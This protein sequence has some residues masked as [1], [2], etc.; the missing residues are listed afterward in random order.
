[1]QRFYK[2][3]LPVILTFIISG[4][5]MGQDF[6]PKLDP[7]KSIQKDTGNFYFKEIW[8]QSKD[9]NKNDAGGYL[10]RATDKMD[11]GFF[12]EALP[13][14]DKSIGIDSTIGYSYFLKGVINLKYDSS[15]LALAAFKKAIALKDDNP[16]CFLYS[17]QIYGNMGKF[18]ESDSLYNRALKINDKLYEGYFGLGNLNV[19]NGNF[20]VAEKN[21]KKAIDLKPEI[22]YAYIN[23]ALINIYENMDINKCLKYLQKALEA[24]PTISPA[25]FLKGHLEL[26]QG[27]KTAALQ[28]W[29]K[30]VELDSLNNLYRITL[31]FLYINEKKFREGAEHLIRLVG[32][33]DAKDYTSDLKMSPDDQR[34]SDF[35]NQMQTYSRFS[36]QL[37]SF[38]KEVVLTALCSFYLERYNA[39]ESYYE[40]LLANP[41]ESAGLIYYLRGFNL[42]YLQKQNL[43][44][45]YYNLAISSKNFPEEA[46]LRR[47]IA[48]FDRAMYQEAINS[49]SQYIAKHYCTRHVFRARANA[50][51]KLA[52][53]DSAIIDYTSFIKIDSTQLNIYIARALCYKSLENYN[54]A[55]DDYTYIVKHDR[56]DD[57]SAGLLAVCMY[58]KGDTLGALN[59]LNNTNEKLSYLSETGYYL[60]GTI[61]LL[62]KQYD[63]AI[64]DY[65]KVILMNPRNA[66]ALIY[67]GLAYYSIGKYTISKVDLKA[68]LK[69]NSDDVTALYTL[70]LVCIK[71][72]DYPAAWDNLH[73][74]DLL[75]HP[76]AKRAIN[77]YLKD[78]HPP[79]S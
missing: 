16:Y 51:V 36:D 37:S 22:P 40:T 33:S 34:T 20:R 63:S 49:F 54:S 35:L 11:L 53:Y 75:G 21:Y 6:M 2:F 18:H 76:L 15:A 17:A 71:I 26:M 9:I 47:G 8:I 38:E 39:A 60:R 27:K 30:A 7:I 73:K 61:Y 68:A 25:Y 19:M 31:A 58:L 46:F 64:S 66:D 43:A 3:L 1:M 70:G 5:S 12:R 23:M 13:D 55:I 57:E 50:Y 29:S 65:N 45:G 32:T 28:D 79:K 69:I 72:N 74:A 14:I 77:V 59:Q 56:Y 10:K 48:F 4:N 44:V 42:E 67:R 24:D 78:Y 62:K 41:S 52:K